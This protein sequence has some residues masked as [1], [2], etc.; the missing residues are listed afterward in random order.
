MLMS[1]R[2]HRF[3]LVSSDH[4]QWDD[5]VAQHPNGSV[6]HTR[7]MIRAFGSVKHVVPLARAAV[8]ESG[9]MVALLVSCHVK[10]L[11]DFESL[12]SRAV[13]YAE[14]LC[15][16]TPH[17]VAALEKLIQ[18][19]D[20]QM[21]SKALLCE[22]RVISDL[23]QQASAL[24]RCGYEHRDYIN[25]VVDLQGSHDELWKRLNK[26]LRQKIRSTLRRQVELRDDN[27]LEGVGRLYTLLQASYGRA[28]VP[29]LGRELFEATLA[30]LP[31]HCVRIRT[32]YLGERPIASI[33]SLLYQQRLFS[34]Y[35]GTLRL[36]GL[37]PFAC[38][39]WDDIEWGWRNGYNLY[40]FGGAGWP[41]EDYGPRR[42]KASFGGRELRHGRYLMT[43]SKLRLRLAELA[44]GVSRRFG[45]WSCASSKDA[46]YD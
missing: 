16:A 3:E 40:D 20:Q 18:V 32:A 35:G 13:Q 43:Y 23:D 42:F 17:G 22:V 41:H 45:V 15:D 30:M 33:I 25:Y 46:E 29:L 19:H 1:A 10:T 5:Y 14:P 27:T 39:V 9:K 28:R 24:L 44:Y 7:A 6:F 36:P 4:E 38:L 11:R 12:S 34:W 31:D 8:D 21:R 37:S 26:N 2:K